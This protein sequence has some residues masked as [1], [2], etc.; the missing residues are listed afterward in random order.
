MISST[1]RWRGRIWIINVGLTVI[2]NH[3]SSGH[4]QPEVIHVSD[5]SAEVDPVYFPQIE[6]IA[7]IGIC[8][9]Q[10]KRFCSFGA[11]IRRD[12]QRRAGP[13]RG[14]RDSIGR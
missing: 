2:E 7:D 13:R 8:E 5:E 3:P 14:I 11:G 1:G 10:M 6:V 4:L 9:W 12:V